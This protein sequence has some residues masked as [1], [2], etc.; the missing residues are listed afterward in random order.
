MR[1][2]KHPVFSL[3]EARNLFTPLLSARGLLIAVSGGSDSRALLD[4]LVMWRGSLND[5]PELSVATINHRLRRGSLQEA[6]EIAKISTAYG[7]T[8]RIM[9]WT[10]PK[11]ETGLAAAARAARYALLGKQVQRLNFD[12]VVTG[13]TQDDQVETFLMRLAAGSG[14]HGLAAMRPFSMIDGVAIARPLLSVSRARL[15]EHLTARGLAWS[16]D[17]SNTQQRFLR[18]RLRQ[19]MPLL[20]V[21]GL[22][23]DRLNDVVRKL[24]RA[25]I[26][27]ESMVERARGLSGSKG[28]LPLDHYRMQP[29]EVRLRLLS[30]MIKAV[31]GD[32]YAPADRALETLDERL[33]DGAFVKLRHTL[34]HALIIVRSQVL[35]VEKEGKRGR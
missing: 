15:R 17:P 23:S 18:P 3:D 5:G 35:S 1:P 33:C 32:S 8:H 12:Y 20:A 9:A 30:A 28:S 7:L 13:H 6:R 10:G 2:A 34:G 29:Q 31:G 26:A 25:D 16:E 14:L 24:A 11:P 27:I 4:L 22:T 19:I 21:E